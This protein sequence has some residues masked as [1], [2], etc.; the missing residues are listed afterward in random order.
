MVAG[1]LL[2]G[3]HILVKGGIYVKKNKK[4]KEK[5]KKQKKKKHNKKHLPH[6]IPVSDYQN[7]YD[8]YV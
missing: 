1:R 3:H 6:S 7:H 5:K 8:E 4:K 2:R